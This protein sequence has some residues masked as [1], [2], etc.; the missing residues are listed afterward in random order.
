[1]RPTERSLQD[2]GRLPASLF[3]FLKPFPVSQGGNQVE[4]HFCAI[5]STG[6]DGLQFIERQ[7]KVA[8]RLMEITETKPS[9]ADVVANH[10][11]RRVRG[12]RQGE[13]V[14]IGAEGFAVA[15]VVAQIGSFTF[16]NRPRTA[17]LRRNYACHETQKEERPK[18]VTGLVQHRRNVSGNCEQEKIYTVF[19]IPKQLIYRKLSTTIRSEL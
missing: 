15:A 8:F 14:L 7:S 12:V 2:L 10:S 1:M 19:N 13:S 17:W 18:H 16:I 6:S 5:G 9:H 3:G 11:R 4:E